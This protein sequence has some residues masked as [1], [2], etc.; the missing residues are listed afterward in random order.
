MS[1]PSLGFII[2]SSNQPKSGEVCLQF[3]RKHYPESYIMI[4]G[5]GSV[6]YYDLSKKYNT[7]YYESQYSLHYPVEPYGWRSKDV[8]NFLSKFYIAFSKTDTTHMMYVEEDIFVLKKLILSDEIEISGYKANYPDGRKFENGFPD[9]FIEII[10]NFSGVVPNVTGYGA[11]GGTVMKVKTFLDN[12]FKIKSFL[13]SNLDFIEDVIYSKAGWID[14]FLT[15]YYLM[16]GKKYT[17]NP[18]LAEVHH[19]KN[20]DI[21]NPPTWMEVASC[22]KKYYI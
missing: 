8:L 5:A 2:T 11:G 15:Y 12:Y 10:T 13:E 21:Y 9:K 22:Y 6:D 4:C 19:D 16:C 18:L 20:F 17:Y 3:I 1:S 7:D 14:C